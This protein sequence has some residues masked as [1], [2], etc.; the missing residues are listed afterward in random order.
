MTESDNIFMHEIK[1]KDAVLKIIIT[2]M[3]AHAKQS[4][5]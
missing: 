1:I 2:N 3:N 4:R 5:Q